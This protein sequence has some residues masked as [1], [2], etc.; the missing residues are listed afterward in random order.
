MFLFAPKDSFFL[1][2]FPWTNSGTSWCSLAAASLQT[3]QN[4]TRNAWMYHRFTFPRDSVA[5]LYCM[6][7]L[8]LETSSGIHTL[9][10]LWTWY[11]NAQR[12]CHS[13]FNPSSVILSIYIYSSPSL[14]IH[15]ATSPAFWTG[16]VSLVCLHVS[17]RQ[18]THKLSH[19]CLLFHARKDYVVLTVYFLSS[20]TIM[21]N[22]RIQIEPTFAPKITSAPR[23]QK[24]MFW[25]CKFMTWLTSMCS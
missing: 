21:T 8:H 23:N 10:P 19:L 16:F 2:I 1:L 14:M 25:W 13:M 12:V 9:H 17:F 5:S 24:T 4:A 7:W 6:S 3:K 18:D 11:T 15:Y 20:A 22:S